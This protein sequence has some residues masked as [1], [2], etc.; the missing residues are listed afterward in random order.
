MHIPRCR[1]LGEAEFRAESD[2]CLCSTRRTG[3]LGSG[4]RG[5]IGRE[6]DPFHAPFP[7]RHFPAEQR[8]VQVP[9]CMSRGLNLCM[10]VTVTRPVPVPVR[11]TVRMRMP[12][13]VAVVVVLAGAVSV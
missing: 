1:G 10:G 9:A 7:D 4:H 3:R 6:R 12:V 5:C 8:Q 13:R 2:G 11:V